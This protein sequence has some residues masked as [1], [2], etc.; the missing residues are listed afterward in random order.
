[1]K[2]KNVVDLKGRRRPAA[3][4]A[5]LLDNRTRQQKLLIREGTLTE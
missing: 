5:Y 1:V 3:E 2:L 4:I